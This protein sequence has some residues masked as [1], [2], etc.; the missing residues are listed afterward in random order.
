MIPDQLT[1]EERTILLQL[2]RQSMEAAVRR[3]P[4]P[5]L[6][7]D[8]YS[9][10][11]RNL[12]VVFITL[13]EHGELRGCIGALDPYQPLA[14]DVCEHAVAAAL[15]DFRFPPVQPDELPDIQIEISRLTL[16]QPFPYENS[17]DLLEKL[18][19]GVDG[20]ILKDGHR[21]VTFLPQVWEKIPYPAQFLS[22]LCQKMGAPPDLWRRKKLEVF[23]Y[24]VGEFH[25]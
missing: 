12:G 18:S 2:A 4:L 13:L 11:L 5:P 19:P 10:R 25:E 16:P 1:P 22:H 3:E 21:R 8:Q 15:S 9:E 14:Q 24:H 6:Q 17:T 7:M 20:V 23:T